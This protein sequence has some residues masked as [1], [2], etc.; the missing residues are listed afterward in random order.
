MSGFATSLIN[1]R[2]N[3]G[4]VGSLPL[5][6]SLYATVLIKENNALFAFSTNSTSVVESSV[7]L[8]LIASLNAGLLSR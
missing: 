5:A 1:K 2:I 6:S 3:L 4:L 7:P 8:L